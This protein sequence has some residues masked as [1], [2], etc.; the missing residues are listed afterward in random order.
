MLALTFIWGLYLHNN[1]EVALSSC[2]SFGVLLVSEMADSSWVKSLSLSC[3]LYHLLLSA[4]YLK[5]CEFARFPVQ[6]HYSEALPFVGL[7]YLD[8][9]SYS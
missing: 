3:L 4:S 6:F 9:A 8:D 5:E 7:F 2:Y 1:E